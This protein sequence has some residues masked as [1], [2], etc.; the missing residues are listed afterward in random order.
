MDQEERDRELQRCYHKIGELEDQ[1]GQERW[2]RRE[3]PD[4][5]P[6]QRKRGHPIRDSHL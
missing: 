4:R 5:C 1:L 6:F 3:C 2:A